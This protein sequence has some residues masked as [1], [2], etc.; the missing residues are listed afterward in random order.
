M[1]IYCLVENKLIEVSTYECPHC[2]EITLETAPWHV[3]NPSEPLLQ[4]LEPNTLRVSVSDTIT[5]EDI[6]GD[7]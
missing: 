1:R 7:A 6:V 2:G 3:L 5:A 4:R